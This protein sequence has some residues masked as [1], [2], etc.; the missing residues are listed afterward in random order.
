LKDVKLL[1]SF[2]IFI[3][4]SS[5]FESADV[6]LEASVQCNLVIK[7]EEF[8]KKKFY[9]CIPKFRNERVSILFKV[10]IKENFEHKPDDKKHA[11]YHVCDAIES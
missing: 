8:P 2:F 1:N 10:K 4:V 7:T 3:T 11:L 9:V 6:E 5:T